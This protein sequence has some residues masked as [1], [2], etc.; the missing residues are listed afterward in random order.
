MAALPTLVAYTQS[1]AFL[2]M[3]RGSL[4]NILTGGWEEPS[5]LEKERALGYEDNATAAPTLSPKQRHE[6]T[7]R[8]MDANCLQN[9]FATARALNSIMRTWPPKHCEAVVDEDTQ[10]GGEG[11]SRCNAA[12]CDCMALAAE[13]TEVANGGGDIWND[14][15][16]LAMLRNHQLTVALDPAELHRV[17]RRAK[18]YRMQGEQLSRVMPD[19]TS[20]ACPSPGERQGVVRGAH[21]MLGHFG[22]RCTVALVQLSHW[23]QGM[24]EDV[25]AVVS[26]CGVCDQANSGGQARPDQLSPLPVMGTF[27]FWGSDT[28]GPMPRTKRGMCTF[29]T[30]SSTS[31]NMWRRWQRRISR[32]AQWLQTCWTSLPGSGTKQRCSLTKAQFQGQFEAI[33]K[34]CHIDHRTT[35]AGHPELTELQTG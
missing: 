21:E 17:L 35:S 31:P 4:H 22:A 32:R 27:Y 16:C 29:T 26:T 1:Y 33:L 8:C 12:A 30:L 7:G 19:D 6:V 3:E 25:I 15:H 10:L 34:Q 11:D 14:V 5:P 18:S 2:P 28:A 9:L 24:Y 20:R 23:W 13:L